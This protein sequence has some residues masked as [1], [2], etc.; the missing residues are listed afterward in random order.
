MQTGAILKIN[1]PI[2]EVISVIIIFE[3][4]KEEVSLLDIQHT[5]E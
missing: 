5:E 3:I 1:G 4:L 2:P